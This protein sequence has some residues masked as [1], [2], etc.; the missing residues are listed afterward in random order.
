MELLCAKD[1]F[2]ILIRDFIQL[3]PSYQNYYTSLLNF[4]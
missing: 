4:F 1:V 2:R 3:I